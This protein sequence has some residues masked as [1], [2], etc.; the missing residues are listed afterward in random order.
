[1]LRTWPKLANVMDNYMSKVQEGFPSQVLE[2]IPLDL[3]GRMKE[4]PICRNLYV[5]DIGHFP[6]AVQHHVPRPDG[7]PHFIFIYCVG[8]HGWCRVYDS[9]WKVERDQAILIPANQPHEYGSAEG[10]SWR[11]YWIHFNGSDAPEIFRQMH[12]NPGM[13]LIYLPRPDPILAAFDDTLRLYHTRDSASSLIAMSGS[14][15]NMLS[16]V[17][18]GKRSITHRTRAVEERIYQSIRSM[19]ETIREPLTLQQLA[20]N[21]CVSVPHFCLL[22]RKLSG[23]T[24]IQMYTQL[25]IQKACDLLNTTDL[26]VKDIAEE[27]GFSDPY[28]F[29]RTF[30]KTMGVSPQ[31]YRDEK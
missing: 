15:I 1:M 19:K 3:V 23:T 4:L 26:L 24:P 28:Y 18:H 25:R 13:P 14:C 2:R 8:G 10:Q 31:R 5:T 9:D 6:E 11:I 29:S 22:F 17:I 16:L 7:F 21:A 27:T 30:R 12:E 20:S